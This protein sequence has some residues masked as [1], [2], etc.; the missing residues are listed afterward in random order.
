MFCV[1]VS[2]SCPFAN[3]VCAAD[4]SLHLPCNRR[5]ASIQSTLSTVMQS[6]WPESGDGP[7]WMVVLLSLI[8]TDIAPVQ[9]PDNVTSRL[10][11]QCVW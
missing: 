7:L 9:G 8:V 1:V 10:L 6:H 11:V 4:V 3:I 5:I 2:V